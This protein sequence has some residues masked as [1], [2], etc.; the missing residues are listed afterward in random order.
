MWDLLKKE[1]GKELKGAVMNGIF[2]QTEHL[3]FLQ[4]LSPDVNSLYL[5]K[6]IC[7]NEILFMHLF[8]NLYC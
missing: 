8:F 3:L 1:K 7:Y 6:E 4:A 2:N 5:T